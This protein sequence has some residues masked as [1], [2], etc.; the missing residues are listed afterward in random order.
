MD[1]YENLVLVQKYDLFVQY[2]Y[3][4]LINAPHRHK[5]LRDRTLDTILNQY[6]LFHSAVKT[7]MPSR[8]YEA[9]AGLSAIR[10][11]IRLLGSSDTKRRVLSIKQCERA[12]I[13]LSESGKILNSMISGIKKKR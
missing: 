5:I 13:M 6:S 10:N 9:D 2:I 3:N 7:G 8:I 12:E 1:R 4:P 11:F